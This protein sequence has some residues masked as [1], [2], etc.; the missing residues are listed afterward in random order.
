M[1]CDSSRGNDLGKADSLLLRLS[2]FYFGSE[3]KRD[4]ANT[5]SVREEYV[6]KNLFASPRERGW[7]SKKRQILYTCMDTLSKIRVGAAL[8]NLSHWMATQIIPKVGEL[9]I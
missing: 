7:W 4:R 8:N 1:V 6:R 2:L 3:W 5:E 9:I